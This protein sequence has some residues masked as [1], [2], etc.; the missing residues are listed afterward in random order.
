MENIVDEKIL[1][2]LVVENLK[3]EL[4]IGEEAFQ[5][6]K[7]EFRLMLPRK[8]ASGLARLVLFFPLL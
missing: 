4:G 6:L 3:C 2:E 7:D 5:N 1:G 8:I